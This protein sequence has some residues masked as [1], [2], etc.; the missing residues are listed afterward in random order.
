MHRDGFPQ[1]V[2]APVSYGGNIEAL[3]CYFHVRQ[4]LRFAKMK[5]MMNGVF[6]IDISAGGLHCLLNRLANR[7]TPFYQMIRE[8]ISSA[9]VI[10]TDKTGVKVNGDKNWFWTW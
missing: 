5:K 7:A 6:N 4:Y 3:I 8:R 10:G 2:D 9:M 1:G